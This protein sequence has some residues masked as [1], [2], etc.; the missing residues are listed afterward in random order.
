[1][2]KDFVE[3][4]QGCIP[5]WQQRLLVE[6]DELKVKL[7]AIKRV[8]ADKDFKLSNHEWELLR[9][10]SCAMREYFQALSARCVYYGLIEPTEDCNCY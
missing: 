4:C 7:A 1:M 10:Q 6:R 8:F 3:Q 2:K 9:H 5:D